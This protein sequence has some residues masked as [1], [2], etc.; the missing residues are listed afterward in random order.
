MSDR[1]ALVIGGGS[2]L[3]AATAVALAADGCS[4]VTAD[5]TGADHVVDVTDEA[6]VSALFASVGRVDVVVNT[7][8]VST[9]AP[10]ADHDAAE[11][12]RVLDVNL[13][14]SFL[15]IKHAAAHLGEGGCIT[16]RNSNKTVESD[17]A[18][19]V[20]EAGEEAG[21]GMPYGCR[22]GICH[23][24]TLTLV[25]GKVRDLRNGDEFDSPNEPVQTCVTTAVGECTFDI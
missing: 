9:L 22:M 3:G 16:F 17:G 20:L 21:V 2:G 11:W 25:K 6:S 12:R 24:C 5:L 1:V 7:A 19:T 10:V 8:G 18:T 13:T 4:V 23:T 15:V 14:G